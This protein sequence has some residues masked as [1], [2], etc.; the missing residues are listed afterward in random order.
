MQMF[1]RSFSHQQENNMYVHQS[2]LK[3]LFISSVIS[4]IFISAD[5][6][7]QDHARPLGEPQ[8]AG[9]SQYNS[10][11]EQAREMI[12]HFMDEYGVPGLSIAI[13]KDEKIVWSEGF[14]FADIENR[15]PVTP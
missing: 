10:S 2:L 13:G 4:L 3:S 6:S 8:A 1:T 9:I 12:I 14:G 15:V 5:L 7:A 11:I